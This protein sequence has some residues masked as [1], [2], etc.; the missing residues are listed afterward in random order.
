M[1]N[2]RGID[3][4]VTRPRFNAVLAPLSLGPRA[5][6]IEPAEGGTSLYQ[7]GLSGGQPL[8]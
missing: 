5:F 7:A 4:Q 1:A 3:D 6:E 8:A 2:W